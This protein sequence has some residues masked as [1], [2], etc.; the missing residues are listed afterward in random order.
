M[1]L[2]YATMQKRLE[3]Q[4]RGVTRASLPLKQRPRA[5]GP[6]EAIYLKSRKDLMEILGKFYT[7]ANLSPSIHLA[8]CSRQH[9]WTRLDRTL[10]FH[11]TA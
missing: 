9:V 2:A 3:N 6:N 1:R 5:G 10:Y 7:A 11:K 4:F 8:L